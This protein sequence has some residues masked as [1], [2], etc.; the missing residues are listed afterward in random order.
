MSKN[1]EEKCVLVC[2]KNQELHDDLTYMISGQ[3]P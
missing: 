1:L 3:K 2:H